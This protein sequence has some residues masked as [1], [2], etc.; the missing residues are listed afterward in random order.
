MLPHCDA[1]VRKHFLDFRLRLKQYFCPPSQEVLY[2][3]EFG[4]CK[5]LEERPTD[6]CGRYLAGDYAANYEREHAPFLRSYRFS[7]GAGVGA[8]GGRSKIVWGGG[9]DSAVA[10]MH[11]NTVTC[12]LY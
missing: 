4:K 7:C 9:L 8:G 2:P 12:A 10:Q 1:G 11:A 6:F 3:M 5:T